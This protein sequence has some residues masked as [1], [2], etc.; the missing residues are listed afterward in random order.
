VAGIPSVIFFE[1]NRAHMS[2]FKY[3]DGSYASHHFEVNP[4]MQTI[5][6]WQHRLRKGT[7]I[8][9]GYYNLSGMNLQLSGKL[10]N[11][12]EESV[13]KLRKRN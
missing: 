2:V 10:A 13:I 11:Q 12:T 7:K 5:A 3:K 4:E 6:I 1:K 9:D 8:F